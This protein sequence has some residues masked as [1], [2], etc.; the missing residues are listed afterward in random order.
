MYLSCLFKYVDIKKQK[1]TPIILLTNKKC[2]RSRYF[3]VNNV[4]AVISA[5]ELHQ[6]YLEWKLNGN[7][8]FILLRTFEISSRTIKC[9]SD[10]TIMTHHTSKGISECYPSLVVLLDHNILRSWKTSLFAMLN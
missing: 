8:Y 3:S 5:F 4:V 7:Y 9:I 6:H 10:N 1:Q 2:Y